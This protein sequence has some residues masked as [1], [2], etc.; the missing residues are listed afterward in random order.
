MNNS[1]HPIFWLWIP[2]LGMIFQIILE[3]SFSGSVLSKM[4]S[5]N[6]P[7]EILQFILLILCFIVAVSAF[8][9]KHVKGLILKTWFA[10]AALASLYVAG[11]EVSWGQ[12]FLNWTTPEYWAAINDQQETNFHNTSSWL[13]QK[14]RL[15][16][17]IGIS[18]GG[19]IAPYLKTKGVLKLP[20]QLDFLIPSSSL[21]V[22]AGFV[23][24]P[25]LVEK[26]FES[27]DIILFAR[28][29]EVQELYMFHFVLLYL[30][31]LF[32]KAKNS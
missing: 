22:I 27:F 12:H 14:P 4:H 16:L 2:V 30:I 10:L 25:H 11:E 7:H 19:L 26:I 6:G 28:Y 31:T 1:L 29:S 8:F 15:I 3:V 20:A 17:L 13:D 23:L 5:E 32:R 24:I 18:F 9:S 21:G